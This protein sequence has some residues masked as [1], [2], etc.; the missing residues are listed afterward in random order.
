MRELAG[1]DKPVVQEHGTP[2]DRG[3]PFVMAGVGRPEPAAA[4]YR[5]AWVDAGSTIG[6]KGA[7]LAAQ[8][9]ALTTAELFQSPETIQAAKAEFDR[10]RGPDA[11]GRCGARTGQALRRHGAVGPS[12][13][14]F[15]SDGPI[16]C[17]LRPRHA[18]SA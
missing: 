17:S 5:L 3:E 16:I 1:A 18:R 8:T 2:W 14:D 13:G 6:L 7:H 15:S 12:D 9:L 11:H 4:G 10:R